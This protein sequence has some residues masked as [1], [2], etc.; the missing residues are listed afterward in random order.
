M[1][2][3]DMMYADYFTY[4]WGTNTGPGDR[5]V[6]AEYTPA[7]SE[8]LKLSKGSRYVATDRIES[9]IDIWHYDEKEIAGSGTFFATEPWEILA[10]SE[11][12]VTDG[13]LAYSR[14]ERRADD[15]AQDF[16]DGATGEAVEGGG[17][18]RPVK[19][20]GR[21]RVMVLLMMSVIGVLHRFL[22]FERSARMGQ[23]GRA[24]P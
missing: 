7:V 2:V 3:S 12:I 16:A 4:E 11:R 1:D 14:S 10:A 22:Y 17:P 20:R 18:R 23:S 21:R 15:H 5:T 8:A 24:S 6:D 13:R 19:R 9:Y